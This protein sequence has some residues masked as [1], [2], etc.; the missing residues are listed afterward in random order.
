MK[1]PSER[2]YTPPHSMF[3]TFQAMSGEK[4]EP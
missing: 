3:E 1:K 4:K 2:L